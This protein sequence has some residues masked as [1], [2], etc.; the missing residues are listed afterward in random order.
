MRI[1]FFG[2]IIGKIGRRAITKVIPELQKE[3]EPDLIIANG[4]NA[5]HGCSITEKTANE[6]LDAGVDAITT[7][8]HIWDKPEASDLLQNPKYSKIILRPANFPQ[9]MPGV[10][11]ATIDIGTKH[12]LIINLMGQVFMK[13]ET[14]TSPFAKFDE[15]LESYEGEKF[16]AIIIDFHAEATSEKNALG[17]YAD[18]R[19]TAMIGTHSHIQTADERIFPGGTAYI[20]DVGMVGATESII[21]ER[22]ESIVNGFLSDGAHKMEIVEEGLCGVSGVLIET[23]LKNLKTKKIKRIYKEIN[24]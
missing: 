13:N 2:D 21:G 6:I 5:A 19:V 4:E 9:G 18:G 14:L 11:A 15:I 8:N 7:G 3:L 16:D 22:I 10:G 20:T 12:I 24:I 17:R 23:G 1:L